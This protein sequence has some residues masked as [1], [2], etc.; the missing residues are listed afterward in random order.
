VG[1]SP[2]HGERQRRG[3]HRVRPSQGGLLNAGHPSTRSRPHSCHTR[4]RS[5]RPLPMEISS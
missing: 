1:A 3:E 2:F 5:R 4:G